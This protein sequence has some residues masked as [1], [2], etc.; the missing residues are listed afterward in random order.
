MGN[1]GSLKDPPPNP[2]CVDL[3]HFE[4]LKVV[5]KGGFGKVNAITQLDSQELLA[6]KRIE[7]YRVIK[8]KTHLHMVWT[9]R[10]I[11]SIVTSP[12]LCHLRYAFESDTELFL[13]MPFLQGGDLRFHLKERGRMSE[14]TARFY[15]A[16][17]ILGLQELHR[18]HIVYR[19]LKPENVLLDDEGHIKVTDFGTPHTRAPHH[20]TTLTLHTT[21]SCYRVLTSLP[22]SPLPLRLC[23]G[24]ACLLKEEDKRR[25]RGQAGTR[26][27]MAPETMALQGYGLSVDY[28]SLGV[29]LYE[30]LHGARPWK[31][32]D[33][34]MAMMAMEGELDP[35]AAARTTSPTNPTTGPPPHPSTH[36]DDDED[37][38]DR[39]EEVRFSSRL[40]PDARSLLLGLL[41]FKPSHRLGAKRGW[42][43]VKAHT[44][45]A[46]I[47]WAA[48]QAKAIPP[49][50]LPDLTH[51]NC[52]P[53]ADLADQLLDKK[54]KRIREEE[55][56]VFE[57]WAWNTRISK[58]GGGGG[59]G[60][61]GE[62]GGG[63]GG[64]GGIEGEGE[65]GEGGERKEGGEE[66]DARDGDRGGEKSTV[67]TARTG[68][69]DGADGDDPP[70]SQVSAIV[71]NEAAVS[72]VANSSATRMPLL[73]PVA[74]NS[75]FPSST[76]ASP[77]PE[78]TLHA[79]GGGGGD[80]DEPTPI[81]L[82][83]APLSPP[84]HTRVTPPPHLISPT[85]VV[86][87]PMSLSLP[88]S[89]RP[90]LT[91]TGSSLLPSSATHRKSISTGALSLHA[92][93][94]GGGGR[95]GWRGWSGWGGDG[96]EE[97]DAEEEGAQA[98]GQQP[99]GSGA[100][101]EQLH[102]RSLP[103]SVAPHTKHHTITSIC[104]PHTPSSD[105]PH[106]TRARL[107]AR[108]PC[109]PT[110]LSLQLLPLSHPVHST[111]SA[112]ILSSHLPTL[113]LQPSTIIHHSLYI[114][115]C[116]PVTDRISAL[117]YLLS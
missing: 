97:V 50:F 104:S 73:S 33:A 25:T 117:T 34:N 45:F 98:D 68:A 85:G 44:F 111:P 22:P 72:S 116:P 53:D 93:E 23:A 57:G 77:P 49:P 78:P 63:G 108:R 43:E 71:P 67:S 51:A 20:R 39:P 5:G 42:E 88:S 115:G 54:P 7:K 47:D 87:L 81:A 91:G 10:Q 41:E 80:G 30:L 94:E 2:D 52:T 28:F 105:Q 99:G 4:L 40:S 31:T 112:A 1:C 107:T 14:N 37:D 76:P 114:V 60:G 101:E 103:R 17:I 35:L 89:S 24:L 113:S 95:G 65:A 92:G 70:A 82:P 61:G 74:S 12:F 29:M 16:Q 106:T 83:V 9:E 86:P 100:H 90:S 32:I 48:M 64:R 84:S 59:G 79:D 26:G 62:G 96:E 13:V 11:M 38:P 36:P 102:T 66:R 109:S 19:D 6:L 15:G 46:P 56:K 21:P 110:S 55:Q 58:D 27:Y 75:L 69:G 8:S 3:S 18:L